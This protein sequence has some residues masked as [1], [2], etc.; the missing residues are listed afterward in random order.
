M[1]TVMKSPTCSRCSASLDLGKSVW[2]SSFRIQ[3]VHRLSTEAKQRVYLFK[4]RW[5]IV[6]NYGC[7][8]DIC[9]GITNSLVFGVNM[10]G[11]VMQVDGNCHAFHTAQTSPVY[12]TRDGFSYHTS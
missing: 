8:W 7:R 6:R 12:A 9:Y 1:R 4:S 11:E 2:R 5:P 3:E 10:N